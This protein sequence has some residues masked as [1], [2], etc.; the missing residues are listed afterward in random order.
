MVVAR[1]L[2]VAR[3]AV[4]RPA[5]LVKAL[6]ARERALRDADDRDDR[7]GRWQPSLFDRRAERILAAAS[8]ESSQ[9]E[10]ER[11]ERLADLAAAG[12]TAELEPWLA[13]LVP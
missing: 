6:A 5:V 3:S 4:P 10:R 11:A 7:P 2:P 8:A 12:A 13:L 9:L 1:A